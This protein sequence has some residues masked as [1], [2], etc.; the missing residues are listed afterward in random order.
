MRYNIEHTAFPPNYK[1]FS[2]VSQQALRCTHR[3]QQALMITTNDKSVEKE[4]MPLKHSIFS[5]AGYG[6]EN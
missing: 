5:I 6:S 3:F 4:K 2:A 1:T